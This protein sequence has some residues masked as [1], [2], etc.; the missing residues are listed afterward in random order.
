[1]SKASDWIGATRVY[2]VIGEIIETV[3]SRDP[4]HP[5]P[6]FAA[7]FGARSCSVYADPLHP[8]YM[9]IHKYVMKGKQIAEHLH[10]FRNPQTP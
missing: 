1:M 4:E 7:V 10:P 9:K 8:M 6:Y 2:L 3:E 5:L